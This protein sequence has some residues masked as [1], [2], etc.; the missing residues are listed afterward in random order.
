VGPGWVREWVRGR[1]CQ[2]T[3]NRRLYSKT[4]QKGM[5]GPGEQVGDGN[6]AHVGD[7]VHTPS[8]GLGSHTVSKIV[9]ALA[10]SRL[11]DTEQEA[12]AKVQSRRHQEIMFVGLAP[13][14]VVS[15][16]YIQQHDQRVLPV[17][18]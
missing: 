6:I 4:F 13:A 9:R 15:G 14:E 8:G 10:F 1:A 17:R 2:I 5:A 7:F 16:P 11:L 3:K 12:Y 18:Q